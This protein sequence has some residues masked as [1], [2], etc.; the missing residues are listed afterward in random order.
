MNT[1]ELTKLIESELVSNRQPPHDYLHPFSKASKDLIGALSVWATEV[2][3]D[4]KNNLW[5]VYTS[6]NVD[7]LCQEVEVSPRYA[8]AYSWHQKSPNTV[9]APLTG[10]FRHLLPQ[11]GAVTNE[12]IEELHEFE[13][14]RTRAGRREKS[15]RVLAEIM[16]AY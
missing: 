11:L 7:K 16:A 9:A 10:L 15:H 4:K 14:A 13:E 8:W 12:E 1:K 3:K 5:L 6:E 2:Y